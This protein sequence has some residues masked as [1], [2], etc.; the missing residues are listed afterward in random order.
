VIR[1]HTP[2]AAADVEL[3]VLAALAA[4]RRQVVCGPFVVDGALDDLDD[5]TR[6][7]VLD[8]LASLRGDPQVVV[9]T[10][11]PDVAAWAHDAHPSKAAVLRLDGRVPTRLD[12]VHDDVIDLDA[13]AAGPAEPAPP[14]ASGHPEAHD[15]PSAAA[16]RAEA[17]DADPDGAYQRFVLFGTDELALSPA[18]TAPGTS[19]RTGSAPSRPV[20]HELTPDEVDRYG[21][22]LFHLAV[23]EQPR[24]EHHGG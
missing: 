17:D 15:A 4:H 5:D 10:D 3:A 14:R 13:L 22:D 7:G 2:A 11:R 1:L 24:P 18:P 12:V 23:D 19:T 6:A 9:L 8:L 21:L 20:R 16:Q